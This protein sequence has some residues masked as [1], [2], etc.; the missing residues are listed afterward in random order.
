MSK[1]PPRSRKAGQRKEALALSCPATASPRCP[2]PHRSAGILGTEQE[3]DSAPR[4]SGPRNREPAPPP[5]PANS[6]LPPQRRCKDAAAPLGRRRQAAAARFPVSQN[7]TQ[8]TAPLTL[9]P[10]CREAEPRRSPAQAA[11]L[12]QAALTASRVPSLRRNHFRSRGMTAQGRPSDGAV[13]GQAPQFSPAAPPSL[14]LKMDYSSTSITFLFAGEF[15]DLNTTEA[16]LDKKKD[17]SL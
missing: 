8:I 15:V 16:F 11:S 5:T 9:G 13:S 12:G 6:A 3:D 4:G 2:H 10:S 7:A 17:S 1:Q 14:K